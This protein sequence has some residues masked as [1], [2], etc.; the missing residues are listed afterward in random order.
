MSSILP[1]RGPR[2]PYKKG[3]T[4]SDVLLALSDHRSAIRA[5]AGNPITFAQ[6]GAPYN[7]PPSTVRD[8]HRKTQLAIA[9]APRHSDTE[10]IIETA[11]RTTLNGAHKRLLTPELE[12]QLCAYIEMCK[13]MAHPLDVDVVRLKAQRLH[14]SSNNIPI[15]DANHTTLAG[16]HWW[17]GFRKRHPSLTLRSPQLLASQR[18]K[19]T[20]TEIINHFYDFFSCMHRST[21]STC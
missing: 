20:Q 4:K 13:Q 18:A 10:T 14:F 17:T 11:V 1:T 6:A 12:Q 7:V 9:R 21:K 2:G 5:A 16:T 8:A 19:A 15:T 3:Y